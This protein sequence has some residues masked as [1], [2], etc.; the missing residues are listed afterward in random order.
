[1]YIVA[2]LSIW[3][4]DADDSLLVEQLEVST[5]VEVAVIEDHAAITVPLLLRADLKILIESQS[6]LRLSSEEALDL[7]ATIKV[8]PKNVAL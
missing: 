5:L 6:Y 4:I 3:S 7:N 1:M 8:R 2:N